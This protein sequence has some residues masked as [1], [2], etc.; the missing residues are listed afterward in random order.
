[1]RLGFDSLLY[2]KG[3][4]FVQSLPQ[5][6]GNL[7]HVYEFVWLGCGPVLIFKLFPYSVATGDKFVCRFPY[8]SRQYREY[9]CVPTSYL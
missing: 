5:L 3:I 8:F 1:M 7:C 2:A 6:M 4:G 9:W